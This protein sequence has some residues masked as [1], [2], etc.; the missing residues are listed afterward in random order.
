MLKSLRDSSNTKSQ[1]VQQL[2]G[3]GQANIAH[4]N[5]TTLQS[6]LVGYWTFDG[7]NTNWKTDT[8]AVSSG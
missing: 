3:I 8:V 2:Y 5:A 7:P 4:S 6:G 1:S